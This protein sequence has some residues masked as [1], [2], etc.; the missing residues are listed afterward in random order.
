[1]ISRAEALERARSWATAGR[2]G[3]PVEVGLYEFDLGYVAWVVEPPQV[4]P[5]RPPTSTGAP[6]VVIDRETGELSQWP[7][8]PA[9]VIASQ[10]AARRAAQDRFPPDVRQVLDKAGWF[11]GR[12]VRAAVDQW[13]VRAADDLAGLEC[14]DAARALLTEFGGLELAQYGPGGV[15]F[16]GFRSWLYPDDGPFTFDR[17]EGWVEETGI[18]LFPVGAYE[19]GPSYLVVD[20]AGRLLLLHW[21]GGFF[22]GTGDEGIINL[23]RGGTFAELDDEGNLLSDGDAG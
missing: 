19:D 10:Y 6:S 1:M 3:A 7:S 21:A 18:A 11:P 20:P 5:S 12:D 2:G 16:G 17:V 15:G 23:I 13:L 9:P 14:S 4:D 22:I 8:L